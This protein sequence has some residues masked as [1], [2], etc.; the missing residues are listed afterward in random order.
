MAGVPRTKKTK[1]LLGLAIFVR[2]LFLLSG[3]SPLTPQGHS[4]AQK[5][6]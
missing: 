3:T 5:A 2:V 1:S 6:F 4:S